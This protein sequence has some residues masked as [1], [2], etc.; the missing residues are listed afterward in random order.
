MD[1]SKAR[2]FVL[3]DAEDRIKWFTQRFAENPVFVTVTNAQLAIEVLTLIEFDLLFLDHDL[4]LLNYAGGYM[5]SQE[6]SSGTGYDVAKFL[7]ENPD[8]Q[9]T[10]EIVIHSLNPSGTARMLAALKKS[11]ER[12]VNAVSFLV[13][14]ELV[15]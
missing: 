10:A 5:E 12:T 13:L 7:E 6:E 4:E 8:C 14:K 2:V 11:G 3:E 15:G 1:K 9:R